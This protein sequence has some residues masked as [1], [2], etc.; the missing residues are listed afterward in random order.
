MGYVPSWE[1]LS[2]AATRVM[3]SAGVSTEE[4]QSDICQ[5]ITDGVIKIRCKLG[6]HMIRH[7]TSKAILD[8]DSFE[9]PSKI[10]SQDLDWE[11]S[12]PVKPWAVLRGKAA[13]CGYW[14]LEWIELLRA[15]VTNIL[16]R[17]GNGSVPVLQARSPRASTRR[18]QPALSRTK[19]VVQELY[20]QGVPDQAALPNANLCRRVGEKLKESGLPEVSDDTILRA[21][22]RRRK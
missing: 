2:D 20:P 9:I 13:Q 6:R 15:D 18:S 17:A 16:C 22:G 4:A 3:T 14:H 7:L 10:N 8:R 19:R 5:A 21:A 1:R 12:R 11:K